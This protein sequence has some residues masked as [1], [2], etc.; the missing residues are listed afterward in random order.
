MADTAAPAAEQDEGSEDVRSGGVVVPIV[1]C[2]ALFTLLVAPLGRAKKTVGGSRPPC[3]ILCR[4]LVCTESLEDFHPDTSEFH[5]C[6]SDGGVF[7][8]P[9]HRVL[10]FPLHSAADPHLVELAT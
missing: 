4:H 5:G 2:L 6:L 1:D 3:S 8:I 10:A 7:E 9:I